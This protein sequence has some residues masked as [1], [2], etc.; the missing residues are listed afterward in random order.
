MNVSAIR[1]ISHIKYSQDDFGP[2]RRPLGGPSAANTAYDNSTSYAQQPSPPLH[3]SEMPT[4]RPHDWGYTPNYDSRESY[5][6]KQQQ[7][8]QQQ[9]QPQ[10]STQYDITTT[11]GFFDEV[12]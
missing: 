10:Q 2:Q 7:Q 4:Q 5:E 6:M 3:Q 11:A 1:Q 9:Q 8:Q 12:G